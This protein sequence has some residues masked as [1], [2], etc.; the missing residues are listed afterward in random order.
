MLHG[1]GRSRELLSATSLAATVLLGGAACTANSQPPAP[2]AAETHA[3]PDDVAGTMQAMASMILQRYKEAPDDR[4]FT[5][6]PPY[7]ASAAIPLAG[8]KMAVLSEQSATR[9]GK[10]IPV[11]NAV[12]SIDVGIY[13]ETGIDHIGSPE[14]SIT[15]V[16][17]AGGSWNGYYTKNGGGA[18]AI[19]SRTDVADFKTLVADA[20]ELVEVAAGQTAPTLEPPH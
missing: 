6:K 8:G 12:D 17:L 15:L 11:P 2:S 14:T 1:M 3:S 20:R 4:R 18:R 16:E 7:S 19:N 5:G 13:R 10:D 9:V